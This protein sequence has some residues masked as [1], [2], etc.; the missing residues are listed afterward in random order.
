MK[1]ACGL[2]L[3]LFF[4]CTTATAEGNT[5]SALV[6]Y[7]LRDEIQSVAQSNNFST[8]ANKL[9]KDYKSYQDDKK[10]GS[11]KASYGAFDGNAGFTSERYGAISDVLCTSAE[12][13]A[14]LTSGSQLTNRLLN[15][16]ALQT[17]KDCEALNA[18]GLRVTTDFS[19]NYE[20][21]VLSFLVSPVPGTNGKITVESPLSDT[22]I[23]CDG[24]YPAI[25]EKLLPILTNVTYR[26]VRTPS[27]TPFEYQGIRMYAKPGI[28]TIPTSS[29]PVTR[30]MPPIYAEALPPT[31]LEKKLKAL[32]VSSNPVGTII[33]SYFSFD[34]IK[35]INP[36]FSDYWLPADGRQVSRD[37]AYFKAKTDGSLNIVKIPDL[38]GTFLR[39][40]NSFG[41]SP[42]SSA[43]NTAQLDPETRTVG[44]YQGDENKNHTHTATI[45]PGEAPYRASGMGHQSDKKQEIQWA[46]TSIAIQPSGG[47]ESR[48][49]N[50]AIYYFIK[51]N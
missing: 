42:L 17:L 39:G 11:V 31:D 19:P 27:T 36:E 21:L 38:R 30:T 13:T 32:S 40:L 25:T 33:S 49:K 8:S 12:N 51:V 4:I 14:N 34:E 15:P 23:S 37:S 2:V 1:L 20:T 22:G 3:G 10:S 16:A 48:P 44:S 18:F 28:I 45:S 7:G 35:K 43:P 47:A 50:Y 29:G 24:P 9:C 5:C 26:C 46:A 6:Q 41:N